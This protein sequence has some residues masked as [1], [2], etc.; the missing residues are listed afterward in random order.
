MLALALMA[1]AC[2]GGPTIA[3]SVSPTETAVLPTA[4]PSVAETPSP[5]APP[6]TAPSPTPVAA[7]PIC[8]A[9]QLAARIT[10]WDNGAGNRFAHVEVTNAGA[11]PCR[12][13]TL[14]RPQLVDGH[15]SV[16]IDGGAPATSGYVLMG[17]GGIL[18]SD[19]DASNYC[20]PDPV[21]PVSIAFVFPGGAAR[22][23]ATPLT[24]TDTSGVPPCFGAPGS[25][26]SLT[27]TGWKA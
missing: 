19:V 13:K 27:M 17:A 20:G 22:F 25:A 18:K 8:T 23:V 1:A 2:T 21:A 26:G 15:G 7:A 16:L 9:T 10:G 11:A 12:M 6:T 14:D 4:A 24:P 5:T 3:P